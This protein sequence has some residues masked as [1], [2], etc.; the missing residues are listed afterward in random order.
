MILAVR[1]YCNNPNLLGADDAGEV[2]R[3]LALLDAAVGEIS[4]A[5]L[6]WLPEDG[7]IDLLCGGQQLIRELGEV[8]ELIVESLGDLV[9]G[10]RVK[11]VTF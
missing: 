2:V 1:T 8:K 3:E 4:F 11:A 5:G 7:L 10:L 6:E 9:P